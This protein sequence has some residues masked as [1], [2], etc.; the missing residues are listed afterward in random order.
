MLYA[1]K[2][3]KH[4]M[5]GVLLCGVRQLC[6]RLSSFLTERAAGPVT[7]A[8]SHN[9]D[10]FSDRTCGS[11]KDV[12]LSVDGD[13]QQPHRQSWGK[14]SIVS[15]LIFSGAFGFQGAS[16]ENEPFHSL[17]EPPDEGSQLPLLSASL[18]T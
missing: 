16:R 4:I 2:C 18:S 13:K 8:A 15:A 7:G 3:V 9:D 10:A 1:F 17:L 6:S 11:N 12:M 14:N 5:P